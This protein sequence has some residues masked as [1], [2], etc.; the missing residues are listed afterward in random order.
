MGE[1]HIAADISISVNDEIE[2]EDTSSGR[3]IS[4]TEPFN[5]NSIKISTP[6]YSIGFLVDR[7]END[8]VNMNTD[9]Q[10]SGDLWSDGQQSRLIESLL[11]G[12][13]LPAF[14]FDTSDNRWG[15]IDGLQRCCSIYNFCV[16]KTLKLRDLDY[17]KGLEQQGFD[18]LERTLKRSILTRPITVNL[19]E[20]G[21][22]RQVRYILFKRLNTGGLELKP[23]EI[24][25]AIFQG[26]ISSFIKRLAQSKEF[27]RATDARI[28]TRRMQDFDFVSRFLAFYLIKNEKYEPDLDAFIIKGLERLEDAS[29][30]YLNKIETDFKKSL[31]LA[32]KIFGNDAFRKRYSET[33]PRNPINKAYFEV[34]TVTFAELDDQAHDNLTVKAPILKH[35]LIQA[36][37]TLGRYLSQG[38]GTTDSVFNRHSIFNLVVQDTLEG[39]IYDNKSITAQF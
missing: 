38:T 16:A 1:N 10:R 24:R 31:N 37:G 21:A 4:I 34:I 19:L 3:N 5:P 13:P 28:P 22:P 35:N 27:I 36:M 32:Y 25:N 20:K 12:L 18:D 17:L 26:K 23:Q 2:V 29:P 39:K 8:E 30:E 9:F 6:P 11:L 33:D 7:L 15:I 14:Y